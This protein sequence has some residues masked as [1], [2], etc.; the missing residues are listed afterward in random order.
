MTS[1]LVINTAHRAEKIV[2]QQKRVGWWEMSGVTCW[3]KAHGSYC[4]WLE[5]ALVSCNRQAISLLL[6]TNRLSLENTLLT[7]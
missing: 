4:A 6:C 2:C 5:K 3:V 7:S 1:V